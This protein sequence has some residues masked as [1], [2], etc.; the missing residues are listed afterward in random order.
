MG[1]SAGDTL[2]MY[3]F[4][5][6][7]LATTLSLASPESLLQVPL[8]YSPYHMVG[9]PIPLLPSVRTMYHDCDDSLHDCDD[10]VETTY[11]DCDP[12]L[13]DCDDRVAI[14]PYLVPYVVPK[15]VAIHH[16][17]TAYTMTHP[18]LGAVCQLPRAQSCLLE[19]T[20]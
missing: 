13:H 5:T 9:G 4:L 14:N 1:Q 3:M 18:Q 19:R 17:N 8:T 20:R 7:A 6:L 11:H 2:S 15:A 16:P 10:R 12:T